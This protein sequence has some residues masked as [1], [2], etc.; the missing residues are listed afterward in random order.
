MRYNPMLRSLPATLSRRLNEAMACRQISLTQLA[1][2]SS[3]TKAAL[4]RLLA[5]DLDRL[6][7]TYTL[8]KLAHA[9]DVNLDYLLGLGL[10]RL[11]AS[12]SFAADFF[13]NPF[14][15]ENTLYEELFLT[16]TSGY[17]VYVC[18]TLPDLLKT[19]AVL[20]IELGDSTMSAAYHAR[21]QALRSAASQRENN[22]LVL[23]DCRVIDDLLTA[24]G[25]YRGL[26][27]QQVR[28]QIDLL[29][30]FFDSQL[31]TVTASVVDYRKTGL[32][33]MFLSTPCRV[34]SRMGDGYV[35][36][37]N[38]ELY[39]HLRQHAFNACRTGVAF[40]AH[41]AAVT[42]GSKGAYPVLRSAR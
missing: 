26:T 24:S 30:S 27:T 23:M 36:T 40:S 28:E 20:D 4:A 19:R 34:A 29:G 39:Q 18:E 16:Q 1:Y 35:C 38:A 10:Q 11:D 8:I 9:L 42:A 41:V 17:F 37:G 7:D 22:G 33:Q 12:I 5:D 32:A 3:I 13:P 21:M 25:L 31:P 2:A 14:S 15:S 6:P